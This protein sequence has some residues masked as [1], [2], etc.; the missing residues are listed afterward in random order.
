MLSRTAEGLF[1]LARYIERAESV[2]RTALGR[3]PHGEPHA[4]ARELGQRVGVDARR[5]RLRARLL[6]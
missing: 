3:P 5:H 1:W 6:A 2:A 4:L